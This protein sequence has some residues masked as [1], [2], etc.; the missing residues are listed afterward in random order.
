[1]SGALSASLR[2]SLADVT[3]RKARSLMVVLGIFIAVFGLTGINTTEDTLVSAFTFSAGYEAA[4]P[5]IVLTVD[6]LD[7]ALLPALSAVPNVQAVQY[8]TRFAT[9]WR[10]A[11]ATASAATPGPAAPG[12]T[13]PLAILSFPD[14]Q[15]VAITPFQLDSGRDPAAG[16]IVMEVGDTALHSVA[17]GDLVTVDTP[18]GTAQLRVVG[19]ARTPG[20]TPA[21]SGAALAYMSNA[22]LRQLV[23][24]NP[25][26][27]SAGKPS[28]LAHLIAVKVQ[29][30]S[31]A[32][33]TADALRQPLQAAGVTVFS[34]NFPQAGPDAGTLH[35]IAG[36]FTLLRALAVVAIVLSGLLILNTITSLVAEQTAVIGTLKAIGG[37]R[38]AILRG[39]LLTVG[40]YSLLATP[41]ALGLGMY[42]GYTLAAMLAPRVPVEVPPFSVD[43]WVVVLSAVV[44]FGVPLLAALPPLWNGTRMSVR[45]AL[46]AYGVS[47]GQTAGLLAGLGARLT[48][49]SQTT[50]LGVRGLFRRRWRAALT[51]LTLTIAGTSFLVVQTAATS[52]NDT[53]GAANAHLATDMTVY[54]ND[55]TASSRIAG[56]LRALP[57]VAKVERS[58]A[59]NV[60]T[61]W[62]TME[63]FGVEPDTQLYHPQLTSGRWLRPGDT[64]VVLLSDD[65]ARRTGLKVGD[66]ITVRD[67]GSSKTQLT[68]TV[69]GT[70]DQSTT[71]LGWIGAAVL[72]VNTVYELRG[73]PAS[74]AP[75]TTQELILQAR[76][77]S[78]PAVNRLASQ[79]AAIVNP[80]GLSSDG[81]GYYDGAG[82]SV[83]TTYE[84]VTRRQGTW[85]I[86]YAMLYAIALIV[87][88]VGA[89]ALANALVASVLDRRRETGM[90]RALGATGRQVA[91]V[92]RVEGLMLGSLAWCAGAVCGLPLAYAFVQMLWQAVMPVHFSVAPLAFAVMLAAMLGIAGLASIAPSWR[93]ARMRTADLLRYE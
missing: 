33:E 56:Q 9:Q 74:Q 3:R 78:Q 14:L 32:S 11:S 92:Y 51:L 38:A 79:V 91:H 31:Q 2:K 81:R 40:I 75:S 64:H 48:W 69:I 17:T 42:A 13:I 16:E 68:L 30:A 77:R 76:D 62:G 53:V 10:L 50:W 85:Y 58:I 34:T 18:T 86:L 25:P 29:P 15:H 55:A 24:A 46:S 23:G 80:S 83:D 72:P 12:S 47:L 65:V 1:M 21:A 54:L 36:I 35:A 20:V 71:V 4:Q 43:P 73:I 57:G 44:G 26:P 6:R 90:L 60:A 22:G 87:A 7:P 49:V 28:P 52:V 8:E 82:G 37:T 59:T 19:L 66:A 61:T 45:D 39:Y 84:Y 70:L 63:I 89:L 27:P 67:N 5:D 41:L 88:A 93:A